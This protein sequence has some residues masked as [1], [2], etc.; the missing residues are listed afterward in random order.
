MAS[1]ASV[2]V[3]GHVGQ[4]PELK[5][6][7]S[8]ASVLTWSVAVHDGRKDEDHTTWYRCTIWGNRAEQVAEWRI[9]RGALVQVSGGLATREY[10]KRTGEPAT[11]LE[12]RVDQ[13]TRVDRSRDAGDTSEPPF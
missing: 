10:T 5:V 12:I 4:E 3:L 2:V 6:T 1:S 9:P 13:L 8:G 11:E 7:P